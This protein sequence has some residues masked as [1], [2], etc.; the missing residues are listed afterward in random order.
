[1]EFFRCGA[2]TA[3]FGY[4]TENPELV[5]IHRQTRKNNLSSP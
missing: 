2:K 4:F 3:G 5:Q 1:M